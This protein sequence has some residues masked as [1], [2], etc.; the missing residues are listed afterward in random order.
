[1]IVGHGVGT[2][3]NVGFGYTHSHKDEHF[4]SCENFQNHGYLERGSLQDEHFET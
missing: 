2:S 1:M 3:F 4:N